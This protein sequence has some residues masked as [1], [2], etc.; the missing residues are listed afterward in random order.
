MFERVITGHGE[1][2]CAIAAFSVAASIFVA[3]SWRAIRMDRSQAGKFADL[4][5]E[6][7]TPE[8]RHERTRPKP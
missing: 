3:A 6:T 4:P 5:F 7:P 8:S 2:I 1:V